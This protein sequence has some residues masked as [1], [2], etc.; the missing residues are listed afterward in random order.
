MDYIKNEK[1][2]KKESIDMAKKLKR[3]YDQQMKEDEERDKIIFQEK[4]DNELLNENLEKLEELALND[5][6]NINDLTQYQQEQ[7]AKAIKDGQLN[8]HISVWEPWWNNNK[9][10]ISEESEESEDEN[11]KLIIPSLP[12]EIPSF[13]SINAKKPSP[14]LQF[15]LCDILCGYIGAM[16]KYN[17]DWNDEPSHVLQLILSISCVLS[18]NQCIYNDFNELTNKLIENYTSQTVKNNKFEILSY[19]KQVSSLMRNRTNIL[20]ALNQIYDLIQVMQSDIL[21]KSKLS[22]SLN[23]KMKKLN[24]KEDI[25]MDNKI[26]EEG[27]YYD[28]HANNFLK[29]INSNNGNLSTD[30]KEIDND[31]NQQKKDKK[32]KLQKSYSS[33]FA[34]EKVR[35]NIK[36]KLKKFD[37]IKRKIWYYL[38]WC[39]EYIS[40]EKATLLSSELKIIVENIHSKMSRKTHN[41]NDNDNNSIKLIL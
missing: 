24:D 14:L 4:M 15:L 28:D 16:I 37:I 22:K 18:N 2:T 25:S 35:K 13:K 23:K 21:S 39:N 41:D 19:L 26:N 36:R 29:L 7:F 12:I 8:K 5:E 3:F 20:R 1:S 11:I 40:N 30:I 27:D 9:I 31:N 32:A 33:S 38:V 17:G 10:I 34:P 6:L